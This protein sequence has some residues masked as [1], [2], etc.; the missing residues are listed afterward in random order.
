[1]L[2]A[3]SRFILSDWIEEY[4]EVVRIEDIIPAFDDRIMN[5]QDPF[6]RSSM[7]DLFGR[8][9]KEIFVARLPFRLKLLSYPR[10]STGGQ[11]T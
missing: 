1:M 7:R 11:T 10:H 5:I 2:S 4:K 8:S 3:V 6:R 9:R